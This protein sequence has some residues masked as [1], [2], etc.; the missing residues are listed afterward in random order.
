MSHDRRLNLRLDAETHERFNAAVSRLT[1]SRAEIVRELLTAA[2]D[3]I[4]R[5]GRWWPP[6]IE[7]ALPPAEVPQ[8]GR[9]PTLAELPAR[10]APRVAEPMTKR[11]VRSATRPT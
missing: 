9:Y 11:P 8:L 5:Y 1:T 2:A 7:P 4:E 10:H 3:Y 6:R